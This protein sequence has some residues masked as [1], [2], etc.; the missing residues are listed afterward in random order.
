LYD[1]VSIVLASCSYVATT[2]PGLNSKPGIR[3]WEIC[4]PRIPGSCFRIRLT[5]WSLFWYHL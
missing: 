2:I 3:D 4:N 1:P 5:N